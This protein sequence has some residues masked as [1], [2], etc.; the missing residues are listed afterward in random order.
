MQASNCGGT[1]CPTFSLRF[2]AVFTQDDSL[3]FFTIVLNSQ[4]WPVEFRGC[5]Q[6]WWPRWFNPCRSFKKWLCPREASSLLLP[7]ISTKLGSKSMAWDILGFHC[8][9]YYV[10]FSFCLNATTSVLRLLDEKF[11][12][13][14]MIQQWTEMSQRFAVCREKEF[15]L[16]KLLLI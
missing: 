4:V 12:N 5:P 9:L 15:T 3:L 14:D 10:L 11:F 8:S 13:E 2:Y 1:F 6:E 7:C 16:I